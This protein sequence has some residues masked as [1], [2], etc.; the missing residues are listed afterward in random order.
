MSG[1]SQAHE[2]PNTGKYNVFAAAPSD[3]EE[4]KK[5]QNHPFEMNHALR[6]KLPSLKTVWNEKEKVRSTRHKKTR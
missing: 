5:R 1:V 4:E 2:A 6:V 3:R